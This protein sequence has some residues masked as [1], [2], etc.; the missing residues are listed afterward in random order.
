VLDSRPHHRRSVT[1]ATALVG[2]TT[3]FDIEAACHALR[4]DHFRSLCAVQLKEVT[5]GSL[6]T[7]FLKYIG[8]NGTWTLLVS[9]K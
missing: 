6:I 7:S 1:L 9:I 4:E 3:K 5:K 8:S 2:E